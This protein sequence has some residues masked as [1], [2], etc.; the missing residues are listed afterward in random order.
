MSH[1]AN[2]RQRAKVLRGHFFST[3]SAADL[4]K[5]EEKRI[6]ALWNLPL[7]REF[8][9]QDKELLIGVYSALK[10]E[11]STA[12]LMSRF[13]KEGVS[14]A[15]PRVTQEGEMHFHSWSQGD[16]LIQSSLG[17]VE[18]C[19]D[20]AIVIPHLCIVPLLAFDEEKGRIGYGQGYYDRYFSRHLSL[21]KIGWAY[22]CQKFETI[23]TD[24][25]DVPLDDVICE[26]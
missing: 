7:F 26:S 25:Y 9:K 8:L 23:I 22:K 19:A 2:L 17:I 21:I 13:S 14:M 11:A 16:S 15:L 12:L 20:S 1:K 24:P 18:P 4:L 3:K 5:L 6:L 10:D